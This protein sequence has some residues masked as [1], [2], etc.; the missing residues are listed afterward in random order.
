MNADDL[1]LHILGCGSATPSLRHMPS[2]QV[3][4]TRGKLFMIDCGEGAQLQMMRKRLKFGRLNNIFISHLHGDHFLGLPGLISTMALHEKGAALTVHTFAEGAGLIQ[5]MMQFLV[6]DTPFDLRFNIIDP[7][8]RSQLLYED[9]GLTVSSFPLFHRVP[10]VGFLFCEKPKGRHIDGAAVRFHGVPHYFMEQLRGG[11]DFVKPDGTVVANDRLTT[12][13]SPS[14]SY[15]Y[16][17]DTAADP[18]VVA[19]I[20]GVDTVFHDAT[21]GDDGAPNA[22]RYGHSTA[23][24]AAEIA[25]RAG[26]RTLVLGHFSKRYKSETELADQAAEAFGGTIITADELMTLNLTRNEQ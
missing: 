26:A 22:A 5:S 15:A 20:R 11:A 9:S 14:A 24:Q 23:R 13:A 3:L 2:C 4:E 6:G 7:G 21:Y 10:A 1:R 12:P 16:C 25:R 17:T 19:S 8:A 18:R